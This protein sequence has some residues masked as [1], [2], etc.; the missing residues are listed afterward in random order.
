MAVTPEYPSEARAALRA[1]VAEHGPD[2]LSRPGAVSN[3]LKD[4]LP[5]EP[6]VARMLV[7]AAEDHV[8]DSLRGH[9]AQGMD[10][11]PAA[12]LTA[13]FFASATLYPPEACAWG[14]GGLAVA[15]GLL[16]PADGPP[17][18]ISPPPPE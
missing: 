1:M 6:R 18:V 13:S 15:L 7:A 10:V 17:T 16:T 2:V 5:D 8:A 3:L 12:R 9:V 4:L 14:V 11:A